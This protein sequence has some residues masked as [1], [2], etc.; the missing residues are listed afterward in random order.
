MLYAQ[1]FPHRVG[2]QGNVQNIKAKNGKAMP[3]IFDNIELKLLPSLRQTL[4]ISVR[5]DF[6]VGYF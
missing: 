1:A 6:C 3:R 5:A 4:E 2:G